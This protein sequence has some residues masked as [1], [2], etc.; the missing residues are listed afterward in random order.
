MPLTTNIHAAP[1]DDASERRFTVRCAGRSLEAIYWPGA[2][3]RHPTLVFLHE[4]LGSANLWRDLPRKLVIATGCSALAYSRYG[5]GQSDALCET[6]D[7]NYMHHEALIVL[8]ELLQQLEINAPIIYGHSDGAS[9]ALIHAGA[10][11]GVRGLVV[12]AP[13]V[14]VES[15][16]LSGVSAA[17]KS[18]RENDLLARLSKH[19]RD[20]AKTFW[21]WHD[22]WMSASFRD[23][24][25]TSFLSNI[26]APTLVIQGEDDAYGTMAQVDVIVSHLAGPT[27]QLRLTGCGHAP[28]REKS[29]Q[30]LQMTTSFIGNI[31]E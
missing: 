14:F 4:G 13:H 24:N 25:I 26:H 21:G 6:R 15:I 28:H 8:P 17:G 16:S 29:E 12:E 19:H 20:P 2:S 7:A 31:I 3:P 27:Q 22:A 1:G 9:I 18:A 11:H 10:G 30:V 23:W 5:Y